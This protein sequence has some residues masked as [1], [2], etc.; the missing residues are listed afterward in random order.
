MQSPLAMKTTN[1]ADSVK[2]A[3]QAIREAEVAELNGTT[4]QKLRTLKARAEAA[5]RW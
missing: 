4:G 2:A 5:T 3:F 1:Q